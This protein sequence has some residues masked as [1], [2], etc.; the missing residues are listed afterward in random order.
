MNM[1]VMG[2]QEDFS[3]RS[4]QAGICDEVENSC[5]ATAGPPVES[6]EAF[7]WPDAISRHLPGFP[8]PSKM[9]SLFLA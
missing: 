5:Y 2:Q 8:L 7:P 9:A 6:V 3:K 1:R 4:I